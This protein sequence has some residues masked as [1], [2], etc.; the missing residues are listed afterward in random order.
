MT[1]LTIKRKVPR[2][3]FEWDTVCVCTVHACVYADLIYL[4]WGSQELISTVPPHQR[5][6]SGPQGP[7]AVIDPGPSH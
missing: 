1:A 4:V 5:D 3:L 6:P 7:W 2:V